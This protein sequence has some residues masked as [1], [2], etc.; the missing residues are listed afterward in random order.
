M[1]RLTLLQTLQRIVARGSLTAAA[2]ELGLG[3]STVSKRL[4][5]LEAEVGLPLLDRTTRQLR[6]T[7]AGQRLLDQ[8]PSLLSA[9]DDLLAT[10]HADAPRME[11]LLR[12]SAPAVFG[13]RHVV[14]ALGPFLRAHPG[15]ELDLVLSDRYVDLLA[16]GFH[17]AIR[18][19]MPVP[20]TLRARRLAETSRVL[21][22]APDT[23]AP[24]SDPAE[25]AHLPA[26]VHG[27]VD[28]AI[29]TFRRG[30]DT[31]RVDVSGRLRAD[32]SE[33]LRQ[34]AVDGLGIALLARWLVHDDLAAGRLVPLLPGWTAP[35]A[36]VRALLPPSRHTPGR[37]GALLDHLAR[38]WA[39]DPALCASA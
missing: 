1:D 37:V 8:A 29:W 3:Q 21:V 38:T 12:I 5:A 33:A 15:L 4:T 36:P 39:T 32:H 35:P 23:W 14:P 22:A 13:P 20:S 2:T 7:E 19:G 34:L 9:W 10:V 24:P 6:P 16:E 27:G 30:V 28:R 26:L 11:G 18:V 25:L 17:L 31:V